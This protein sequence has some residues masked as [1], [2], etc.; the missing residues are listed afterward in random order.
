MI[1]TAA[2]TTPS[3]FGL[4]AR[5][6]RHRRA[7]QALREDRHHVTSAPSIVLA[8]R[9]CALEYS[10]TSEALPDLVVAPFRRAG[11]LVLCVARGRQPARL[12]ELL[13]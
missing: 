12:G 2:V 4:L 5:P 7:I 9:S 6:T 10:L 13:S 1:S 8:L 11:G 3:T